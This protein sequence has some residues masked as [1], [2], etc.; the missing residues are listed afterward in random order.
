MILDFHTQ[1]EQGF[2][3]RPVIRV[4]KTFWSVSEGYFETD[5]NDIVDR[6]HFTDEDVDFALKALGY[7]DIGDLYS[8]EWHSYEEIVNFDYYPPSAKKWAKEL[9][10][11]TKND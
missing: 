2:D 6:Y 5:T 1:F 8:D 4:Y 7:D 11:R 3:D 10:E 9:M